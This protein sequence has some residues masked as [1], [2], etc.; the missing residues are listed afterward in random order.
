MTAICLVF[1]LF[2]GSMIGFSLFLRIIGCAIGVVIIFGIVLRAGGIIGIRGCVGVVRIFIS[3]FIGVSLC[4]I[5][6]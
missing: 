6:N 5:T 1:I 2:L 3:R 4:L